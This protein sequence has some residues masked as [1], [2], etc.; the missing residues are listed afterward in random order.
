MS[1]DGELCAVSV[2]VSTAPCALEEP[3]AQ[4]TTAQAEDHGNS[5]HG[6]SNEPGLGVAITE[7][8]RGLIFS[9]AHLSDGAFLREE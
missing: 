7:G 5:D 2:S 9:L 3:D 4:A 6:L 1:C 8:L